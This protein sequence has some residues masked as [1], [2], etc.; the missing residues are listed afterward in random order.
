MTHQIRKYKDED[1]TAILSIWEKASQIAHSFLSEEFMNQE[2][3]NLPN[4][5]IPAA[6]TWI[7]EVD[8]KVAGFISLIG[9]EVGGLFVNP[10]FQRLG[11]GRSLM[12]KARKL[13]GD[14]VVEVYKENTIG[15]VFYKRYG[16]TQKSRYLHK[17]SGQ[18]M[19]RLTYTR[20]DK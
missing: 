14:L 16:F 10:S 5:Y 4:I 7:A 6:D 15:R 18:E 13:H 11:I 17:G 19:L 2:R 20:F 3:C 12:N 9:N 1:L 8:G